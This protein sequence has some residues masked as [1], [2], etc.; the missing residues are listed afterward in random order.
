MSTSQSSQ[1]ISLLKSKS[2][3]IPTVPHGANHTAEFAKAARTK[4]AHNATLKVSVGLAL[5][6]LRVLDD[7]VFYRE[8]KKTFQHKDYGSPGSRTSYV[9]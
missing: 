5:T 2:V 4:E 1:Y 6:G 9:P 8:V 7:A 3:A